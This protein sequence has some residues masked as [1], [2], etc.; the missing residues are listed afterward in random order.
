MTKTNSIKMSPD[1]KIHVKIT[2]NIYGSK[3][4]VDKVKN[5]IKNINAKIE[6]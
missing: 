6:N 4:I 2:K 5:Y 3:E 1:D